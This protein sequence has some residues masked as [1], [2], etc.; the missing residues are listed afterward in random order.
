M[1]EGSFKS[2]GTESR[3]PQRNVRGKR[4]RNPGYEPGNNWVECDICASTIRSQD[5]RLTWDNYVVCPDDWEPRHPQDFVRGR[6][7]R[8]SAAGDGELGLVRSESEDVFVEPGTGAVP[9]PPPTVILYEDVVLED[10]PTGYW[11]FEENTIGTTRYESSVE[12]VGAFLDQEAVSQTDPTIDGAINSGIRMGGTRL[13]YE[14]NLADLIDPDHFTV[15]F[16]MRLDPEVRGA[17]TSYILSNGNSFSIIFNPQGRPGAVGAFR[18]NFI[19]TGG[20]RNFGFPITTNNFSVIED[21]EWHLYHIVFDRNV[22]VSGYRDGELQRVG[23]VDAQNRPIDW[24]NIETPS[25]YLGDSR[26]RGANTFRGDLDELAIYNTALTQERITAHFE[27]RA[28]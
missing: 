26:R 9:Q 2:R 8:I 1:A 25:N 7:D 5:A 6:Q 18:S 24:T 13:T 3:V 4:T 14:D 28:T 19:P 12:G 22:G 21:N 20:R 15:E 23:Q 16:W 17:Q 11:R 27:A 10:E